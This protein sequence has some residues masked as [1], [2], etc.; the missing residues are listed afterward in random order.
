MADTKPPLPSFT[1]KTTPVVSSDSALTTSQI[2]GQNTFEGPPSHRTDR[3]NS[4]CSP[5]LPSI[6]TYLAEA[7]RSPAVYAP[8]QVAADRLMS[9]DTLGLP[10]VKDM[11]AG[12]PYSSETAESSS[13][14]KYVSIGQ[15][16]GHDSPL[17]G[18]ATLDF[19][20]GKGPTPH[21]PSDGNDQMAGLEP[22]IREKP[23]FPIEQSGSS[24]RT[25]CTDN[26][27]SE[28]SASIETNKSTDNDKLSDLI[29]TAKLNPNKGHKGE[30]GEYLIYRKI[31]GVKR[32]TRLILRA[33]L[34]VFE[35]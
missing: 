33:H 6:R 15:G 32:K 1:A 11:L 24:Q 17:T 35:G 19:S 16:S 21:P 30:V 28:P 14:L 26:T 25:L 34:T 31:S 3:S 7:A 22:K 10:S 23:G 5:I 20:R 13:S 4:T 9:G 8:S 18:F 29:L 12:V 27:P 2:I